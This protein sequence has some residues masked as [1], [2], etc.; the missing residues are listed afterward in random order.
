[1]VP[2]SPGPSVGVCGVP[3]YRVPHHS[4]ASPWPALGLDRA[5]VAVGC[6]VVEVWRGSRRFGVGRRS[7]YAVIVVWFTMAGQSG[8]TTLQCYGIPMLFDWNRPGEYAWPRL[9]RRGMQ[10]DK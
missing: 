4:N 6:A 3:G 5:A 1:M 8:S 10:W 9:V 2:R 7:D